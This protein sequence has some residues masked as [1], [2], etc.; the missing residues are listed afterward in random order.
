[1]YLVINKVADAQRLQKKNYKGPNITSFIQGNLNFRKFQTFFYPLVGLASA[2]PNESCQWMVG[3]AMIK[4]LK[5]KKEHLNMVLMAVRVQNLPSTI[6]LLLN[7]D[8]GYHDLV[9]TE[10]C[11]FGRQTSKSNCNHF[12]ITRLKQ[13][14]HDRAKRYQII[15][16]LYARNTYSNTYIYKRKRKKNER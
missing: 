1:M 6:K 11:I 5:H 3:Y 4:R 16:I 12:P 9:H 2:N 13:V 15:W 10:C 7:A 8:E 14:F